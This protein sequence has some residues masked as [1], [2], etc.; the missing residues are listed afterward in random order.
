MDLWHL[1]GDLHPKLVHVPLILL[2][3]GLLFDLAG[4]VSRSDRCHFAAKILTASGTV[5]LLL[6]LTVVLI[7]LAQRLQGQRL[8]PPAD[9][10]QNALEESR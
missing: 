2:L 7:A 6:L 10:V 1:L 9:S 4:L 3:A 8:Q 5:T